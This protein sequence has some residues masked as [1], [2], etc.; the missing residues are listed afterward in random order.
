VKVTIEKNVPVPANRTRRGY[1][2]EVAAAMQVGDSVLMSKRGVGNQTPL[3]NALRRI[4]AGHTTR[5]EEGGIRV[6][7][8]E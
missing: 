8:T 5:Q 2:A 1:W 4:G 3:G 6:W 7:R